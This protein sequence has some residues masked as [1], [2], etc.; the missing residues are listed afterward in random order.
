MAKKASK[1]PT[2]LTEDV[3]AADG[4]NS[5]SLVLGRYQA[6][7]GTFRPIWKEAVR[8]GGR[9]V[10]TAEQLRQIAESRD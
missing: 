9:G 3:K 10:L 8:G 6:M 7:L 4:G 5:H 2:D 1:K